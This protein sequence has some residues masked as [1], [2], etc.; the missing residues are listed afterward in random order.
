MDQSLSDIT[1][2]LFVFENRLLQILA[3]SYI[4]AA[5]GF[6]AIALG[7]IAGLCF[8]KPGKQRRSRR[9]ATQ[10]LP[11]WRAAMSRASV[12]RGAHSESVEVN[13]Y[14]SKRTI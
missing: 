2:Y 1:Q 13:P 10:R 11:A 14:P 9:P 6:L 4:V 12:R 7:C 3:E 5:I 8:A